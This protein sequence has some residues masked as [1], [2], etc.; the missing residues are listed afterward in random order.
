MTTTRPRVHVVCSRPTA[1][2][3]LPRFARALTEGTGWTLSDVPDPTA[4][5]NYL[6]CYLEIVRCRGWTA[7]PLAAFF[8]HFDGSN[9]HKASLWQEAAQRVGLRVAMCRQYAQLLAPHGATIQA[10]LPLDRSLFRLPSEAPLPRKGR[11]IVGVAGFVTNDARKGQALIAAAAASKAG[12]RLEWRAAGVGWPVPTTG[13][14]WEQLPAFYQGL[15]LYVCPSLLEGGPLPVLEAMACG[16]RCVLPRGVGLLDE[17]PPLPD[18]YRYD[19]G[20]LEGLLAA[21]EE[22]AFDTRPVDRVALRQATAAHTPWHWRQDHQ[23]AFAAL[24][25]QVRLPVETPSAITSSPSRAAAVASEASPPSG[26]SAADSL[27]PTAPT[28]AASTTR[29]DWRPDAG[30]YVVA[31]GGP[32]RQC[33]RRLLASWRR[34]M[35]GLPVALC[36]SERLAD[37][38]HLIVV[39]ETDIGARSAKV[40]IDALAPAEWR[41]ILYLDADTE[42]IA[43]VP[44]LFQLVH[45]GWD[46]VICKN[47]QRFQSA[48]FMRRPDNGDECDETFRLW[49]GYDE[50]LRLN[51]GVFASR[52]CPETAAFFAAWQREWARW[53]KRDQAALLRALWQVPV[54]TYVLGNEWNTVV[55]YDPP[56]RS[57][58]ILHHVEEARRWDGLV[59]PRGDS[60]EAWVAVRAW[61]AQHAHP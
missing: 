32:A 15:D 12:Q 59:G 50:L 9:A 39:P 34:H 40:R 45:D 44:F 1:D 19:A 52:R 29:G 61:E 47:P 51:G 60:P 7:T 43:P 20:S 26:V 5:L 33:A 10:R 30:L 4:A 13:Y 2:R 37:E 35:P 3:I 23:A 41:Y 46:F 36:S 48:R 55:R 27:L 11:P 56:G 57:A 28:I 42:L 17:F 49:G 58:G 6:L 18:L 22:A 25:G 31:F 53:G 21:V 8:T 38:E 24:L 14:G 54:R 16:T